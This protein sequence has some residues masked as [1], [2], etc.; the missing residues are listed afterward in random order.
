MIFHNRYDV[1]GGIRSYAFAAACAQ[2]IRPILDDPVLQWMPGSLVSEERRSTLQRGRPYSEVIERFYASSPEALHTAPEHATYVTLHIPLLVAG[3]WWGTFSVNR[4]AAPG[5]GGKERTILRTAAAMVAQT[6][7][8]WEA[9]AAHYT[10]EQALHTVIGAFPHAAVCV[11]DQDLRYQVVGG[12]ALRGMGMGGEHIEGKTLWEVAPR[13]TAVRLEPLFRATLAGTAPPVVEDE[14]GG[15]T[16]S[17]QPVTLR[18]AGGN[19]AGGMLI[20]TDMTIQRE[21]ESAFRTSQERHAEEG[22]RRRAN[23]LEGLSQIA[24]VLATTTNLPGALTAAVAAIEALFH[25]ARV[26]IGLYDPMR[27]AP[28]AAA[29]SAPATVIVLSQ[30]ETEALSRAGGRIVV[31][32]DDPAPSEGITRMLRALDVEQY[33]YAVLVALPSQTG[34]SGVLA[35]GRELPLDMDPAA[36]LALA[37]T[38]ASL[39]AVSVEQ[40]YYYQHAERA[41]LAQERQRLSRTLHDTVAQSLYSISLMGEAAAALAARGELKDIPERFRTLSAVA[42]QSHKGMRQTVN[43][44]RQPDE[45]EHGLIVA[46]RRWLEAVEPYW[47]VKPLLRVHGTLPDLPPELEEQIFFIAREALNNALRHGDATSIA[48]DVRLAEGSIVAIIQDNGQGFDPE[49]PSEG[50]GLKSMHE[51]A[52]SINGSLTILSGPGEGTAVEVV[53]PLT[54]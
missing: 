8:R 2:G 38:V 47:K 36:D 54:A 40:H 22:L 51:R 23:D 30:E 31:T 11:F 28:G 39:I 4:Q 1:R 34:I 52:S 6:I 5:W 25:A 43:Q 16:Y 45:I 13:A 53:V 18:D 12:A 24:E 32:R 46:L 37:K 17:I 14:F 41:I 10:S 27:A 35:I 26:T 20:A 50:G 44:L 33:A 29:Q 3:H 21:I 49:A 9:C 7:Q 42:L 48:L 15:R 19:I